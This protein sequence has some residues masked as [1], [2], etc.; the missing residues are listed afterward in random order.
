MPQ[1]VRLYGARC[2]S[3]GT[4]MLMCDGDD[5]VCAPCAADEKHA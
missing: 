4:T 3:C 2:H 5:G 1:T